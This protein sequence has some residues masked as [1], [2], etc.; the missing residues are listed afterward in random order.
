MA[1]PWRAVANRTKVILATA[2]TS[3]DARGAFVGVSIRFD[4]TPCEV[5]P[6]SLEAAM[7]PPVAD[8]FFRDLVIVLMQYGVVFEA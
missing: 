5:S 2:S 3:D 8:D 1:D 4:G 6:E 7:T